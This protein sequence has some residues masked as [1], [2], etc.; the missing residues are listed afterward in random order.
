[1]RSEGLM[2]QRNNPG[3]RSGSVAATSVSR[4][5]IVISRSAI[6]IIGLMLLGLALRVWFVSVNAIDPRFSTADD[7]DYYQRALRFAVTGQYVD[8]FWLIRPPLHVFMFALLLR[9]SMA[10]GDLTMGVALIRGVQIVLIVLT[11]PLGYDLAR[12]L[13]GQRAGL[14]FAAMLAVWYPLIELPAHTYSEPLFFVLFML[15]L[16]T[17]VRWRDTRRWPWLVAAGITLGLAAL[18]RSPALY[19]AAFVVLWLFLTAINEQPALDEAEGR[20]TNLP[21][22]HRLLTAGRW[23]LVFLLAFVVV[24]APWTIRNY[25]VYQRFIPI[26]TLG[27]PNLW[28]DLQPD[29]R[30]NVEL[31]QTMPQADRQAFAVAELKRMLSEDPLR[32]WQNAWPN[33]QHIWK[34]QF[35][36]DFLLK[37]NFYTRPLRAVWPL[38]IF[39]DVLWFAFTLCG[40]IGLAAPLREGAF[41]WLA[42]CWLGYTVLTVLLLH[43]EPRYLMPIWLVLMLYAAWTMSNL[44]LMLSILLQRRWHGMLALALVLGFLTIFF[45]YRG[46]TAPI[47]RGVQREWHYI[48]GARAYA[49]GEYGTAER[50][51]QRM[52]AVDPRS[53]DGRVDLARALMAQGRYDDALAVLGN[54]SA[55]RATVIRAAIARAQG[56]PDRAAASFAQAARWRGEDIQALTLAW[57]HPPATN[58]LVLGD[59]LDYGYIQGF[60]F[61]E[62]LQRPGAAPMTYRWL[63]GQGR[64][65]VPLPQ[66]LQPG[67][68]VALHMTSGQ[69]EGTPLR[70]DFGDGAVET[71]QVASGQWRTYRLAVPAGLIGQQQIDL[72]LS[73]PT[74][75]PARRDPASSDM[76]PL[77]LMISEVRVVSGSDEG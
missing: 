4:T 21:I 29:R 14:I 17:L 45:T 11:I 30:A 69:A 52:V 76:R 8:D 19:A 46:Y 24:V 50:E 68:V 74:F 35:I 49:A 67:S 9:I 42:L 56:Q 41:R 71:L 31:L 77:S 39:G 36:E 55:N 32:L 38:G 1:M 5:P 3:S 16:W 15:H 43:V 72:R 2:Y 44:S 63:Q 6:I 25:I 54:T 47:A 13:F 23:S 70:I 57:L 73:A 7:G 53:I 28:L 37:T 34:A 64:I 61:G 75:I 58:Q 65:V 20:T 59:E 12:R 51:F 22:G 62:Q 26:D 40:L 10:L 27:P 66:P 60:S 33:F 48:T 18:T